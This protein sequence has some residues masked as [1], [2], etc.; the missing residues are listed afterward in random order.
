MMLKYDRGLHLAVHIFENIG[1][2]LLPIQLIL[3]VPNFK[4]GYRT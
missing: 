2:W 3:P 4:L 1:L